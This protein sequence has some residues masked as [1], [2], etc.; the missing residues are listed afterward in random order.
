MHK[1]GPRLWD[2]TL[3]EAERIATDSKA[4]YLQLPTPD[5]EA[6]M[7]RTRSQFFSLLR[8]RLRN[9]YLRRISKLNPG[10][11]LAWKYIS[12]RKKGTITISR[13][14][15][16]G[17]G[18][19]N[20]RAARRA[21]D[22]LN[23]RFLPP[24]KAVRF[25]KGIKRQNTE[26]SIIPLSTFRPQNNNE[27]AATSCLVAHSYSPLDAPFNRTEPLAALRSTPYGKA[28]GPDEV[29]SEALRHISSK[30]LRFLLRCVNYSWTTGTIPAE[31]RRATIVPLLKPGKSPELLESYRSISLTSIVS[32]VAEKMVLKRLLWVWTPHPHQYAYRSVRTTTMQRAHLIH[33]V[34]HNRNDYFQVNLPNKSGIGNQ[35]HYRPHRT[36]LALVDFSKALHSMDHR[37]LSRLLANIPGRIVEGGFETFY[38]VGTRR[39]ELATD[40]V[41]GV[42]CCEEFLRGP[43]WDHICSLFTYTHFSIC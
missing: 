23:R 24:H 11:P 3:M 18:H 38:V 5:R 41:I 32:K 34:E 10:E 19:N 16:Y 8:E 6:D 13:I 7:Q 43:Y 26:L 33:E 35:L 31:W 40:T 4:R 36:L 15:V 21:A 22:A 12:G 27:P 20:Y 29:D 42:P 25:S 1:D 28:P 9:T 14:G 2:D 37:V 17:Y 39:H 30:G